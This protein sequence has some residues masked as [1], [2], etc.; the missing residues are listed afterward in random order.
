[1]LFLEGAINESPWC[2]HTFTRIKAPSH[3][4]MVELV[5]TISQC[6]RA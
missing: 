1:M 6:R 2:G 4:D 3:D 5:N